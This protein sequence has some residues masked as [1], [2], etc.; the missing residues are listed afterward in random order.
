[1]S[2]RKID[3]NMIDDKFTKKVKDIDTKTQELT[4]QLADK[5]GGGRKAEPEDL[6]ENVL[7]LV[8]GQGTINLESIPQNESVTMEKLDSVLR[9]GISGLLDVMTN[10]NAPWEVI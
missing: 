3:E 1:M 10:E 5:V 6:S 2:L 8:T 4:S 9:N 7:A